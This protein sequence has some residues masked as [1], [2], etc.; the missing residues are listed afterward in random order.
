MVCLV[1]HYRLPKDA[2]SVCD[3]TR[4]ENSIR[5]PSS[6]SGIEWTTLSARQKRFLKRAESFAKKREVS[7]QNHCAILVRGSKI[8]AVGYNSYKNEPSSLSEEHVRMVPGRNSVMGVGPHAE[9][10]AMNQLSDVAGMTLYVVRVN[11]NGELANSAPCEGCTASAR[12]RGIR[13]I[14]WSEGGPLD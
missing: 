13:R 12:S 7:F 10:D 5:Y 9:V 3:A 2:T 4:V 6:V 8:V 11:R 1:I 14:I